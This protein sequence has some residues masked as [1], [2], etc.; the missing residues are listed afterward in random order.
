MWYY[1]KIFHDHP[2]TK[3]IPKNLRDNRRVVLQYYSLEHQGVDPTTQEGLKN[4]L[5]LILEDGKFSV[6]SYKYARLWGAFVW[7]DIT[8]A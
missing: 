4:A 1:D 2:C 6:R 3:F 5:F 7:P 8:V